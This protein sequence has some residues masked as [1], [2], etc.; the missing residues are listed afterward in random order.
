MKDFS[1]QDLRDGLIDAL[2]HLWRF[3]MSL[4]GRSDW[5]DDLVQN[6]CLR[7]LERRHQVKDPS[8]LRAWLMSICRSI[9]YNELRSQS[10]R[11]AQSLDGGEAAEVAADILPQEMNIFARE[12]LNEVMGL[13]EAQRSAVM[14]VFV[15]GFTYREAAEILDVPIGTVMSR[16]SAARAKLSARLG[17]AMIATDAKAMR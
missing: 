8:G 3:A 13:P 9:W 15:E 17:G 10:V 5:A 1:E 7:A 12:V 11:R 6:T 4:T 14:L 16:L 2:P